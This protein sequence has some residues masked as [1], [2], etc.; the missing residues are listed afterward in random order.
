MHILSSNA[1][2]NMIPPEVLGRIFELGTH[3]NIHLVPT[4]TLVSRRWRSAAIHTPSLWS[5]IKL[6]H[7]WNYGRGAELVRKIKVYMARA[8]SAKI[9]VDL[10]FRYCESLSEARTLMNTLRPHLAR[11]FSFRA[12]VPDWDW[13][14]V[15]AEVADNMHAALEAFALRIDPGDAEETA[16]IPFLRGTFP[17]L[18]TVT[19]E[20]TPLACVF[21]RISAPALRRFDLVRDT[22][23]HTSQRIRLGLREY[24]NALASS[25]VLESV[26]LQNAVFALE[27][28]ETCIFYASPERTC[29][30]SLTHLSFCGVDASNIALLLDAIELPS[31]F[32]L[33]VQMD[34]SGGG[35]GG[36][37][38]PGGMGNIGGA[39]LGS[40]LSSSWLTRLASAAH[41]GR[42]PSLR[43]LE[44]RNCTTD[45]ASALGPLVQALHALPKLQAFGIC[46]PPSGCAGA[47][48]FELL[49]G[50][51]GR[52][53]RWL[54]PELCALRLA[55]CRDVTGHEV[56]RVVQA[57]ADADEGE[58]VK[59]L[60]M[61]RLAP[62]YPLDPEVVDTLR[63]SVSELRMEG[64]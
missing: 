36:G 33:F 3:E 27:G 49:A 5:Y 15:V 34:Y 20:Q 18:R 45:G 50:G 42:L 46:A 40:D 14:A 8:G 4:L 29:I 2:I 62:C 9:C 6:D 17:R 23:Y 26:K 31:L 53:G 38:G 13:M 22:R 43:H 57:R 56:L 10:D 28:N 52:T 54:V 48:L 39:G 59:R 55:G 41:S 58:G 24:L 63:S 11:C 35:D 25:P 37:G 44:L 47:R 61:V 21:S 51:P 64:H 16:P 7:D 60:R 32:S 12:S 1:L 30:P 19:L